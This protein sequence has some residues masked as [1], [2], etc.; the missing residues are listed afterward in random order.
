MSHNNSC[1]FLPLHTEAVGLYGRIPQNLSGNL[2]FFHQSCFSILSYE[3][4]E[5][6]EVLAEKFFFVGGKHK[7]VCNLK[8]LHIACID[9]ITHQLLPTSA[10]LFIKAY[11]LSFLEKTLKE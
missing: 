9:I 7:C 8:R 4:P 5:L 3:R 1:S 11:E 2:A 10:G 6:A